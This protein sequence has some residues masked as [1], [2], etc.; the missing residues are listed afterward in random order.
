[1]LALCQAIYL[2]DND[3]NFLVYTHLWATYTAVATYLVSKRANTGDNVQALTY[4]TL[5]I[6]TVPVVLKALDD[7]STYS[8]LL[9]FEQASLLIA[10]AVL[11]KK[12]LTYWGAAVVVLSV[13]YM[14]RSFA[15]LQL[16]IIAV[17]L[18]GYAIFR[19]TRQK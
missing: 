12:P 3:T 10:G 15:Y 19:L 7:T 11:N 16:L 5:V 8:L 18:I 17:I 1:M 13:V 2:A 14:L 9:L 6:F 4:V